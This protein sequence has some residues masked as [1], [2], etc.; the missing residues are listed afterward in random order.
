M[1]KARFS[2]VIIFPYHEQEKT[3]ASKLPDKMPEPVIQRRI[4]EAQ[5]YPKQENI[6][7][8]LNCAYIETI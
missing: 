5:E 7:C 1:K 6:Q 2:S 4:K 3:P 8:F